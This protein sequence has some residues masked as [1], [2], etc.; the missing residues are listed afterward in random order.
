MTKEPSKSQLVRMPKD[1]F[2][3]LQLLFATEN[4]LTSSRLIERHYWGRMWSWRAA[5]TAALH[6]RRAFGVERPP[7]PPEEGSCC[8]NGCADCV[9]VQYWEDCS[10]YEQ[11]HR[12][13][14]DSP[15]LQ[16]SLVIPLSCT[17]TKQRTGEPS[18]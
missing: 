6:Q 12:G 5:R 14:E 4:D 7:T 8:G 2:N 1:D 13:K 10:K 3:A 16:V 11:L 17:S 18:S 15:S 9:W